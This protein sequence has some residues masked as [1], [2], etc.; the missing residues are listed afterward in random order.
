MNKE[1]FDAMM[2]II[3]Y[4]LVG[5]IAEK[6]NISEEDAIKLLYSS[7]LYEDLE[8]EET[9]VWHYSK[10]MLYSLLEQ[11]WSIGTIQYPDV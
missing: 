11:E 5:I 4:E 9:K 3:V 7:K 1:Q 10:L 8:R 2:P 6:R